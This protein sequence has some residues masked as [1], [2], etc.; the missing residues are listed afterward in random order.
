VNA[1][2][3]AKALGIEGS[4][5]QAEISMIKRD[6]QIAMETGT[7]IDVQ[8]ISTKEGVE[9]V[10]QAR[11]VCKNIHAEA[12]PHHFTLTDEA[13][14][15][16]GTL[17]KMNPPLRKE[18]D[19]LEIIKGLKD[20]TIEI[21]A[22]DHAPHSEEEKA[23]ELTQAPSGILGLE[24]AFSLGITE[25]V[26]K[27]YLELDELIDRMSLS[28]AKLYGME[29]KIGSV[30]EG[31]NADLIIF[32]PNEKYVVEGYLSKSTNSPFTGRELKGKIK[33]TICNGKVVYK[34]GKN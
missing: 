31:R 25:L 11:K 20:G 10:R 4:D 7:D 23:K 33:Y 14:L 24:T 2:D 13:V 29:D 30:E 26:D 17:A 1:G 6:V 32:D 28:P 27:G 16:H 5:R 9:I 34:D 19:R 3:V 22:T 12:T 8:H 18:E 15:K 21:I